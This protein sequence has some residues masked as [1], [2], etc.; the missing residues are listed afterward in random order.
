M[1]I[2]IN[3]TGIS[4]AYTL[5]NLVSA[6]EYLLLKPTLW[7]DE[8]NPCHKCMASSAKETT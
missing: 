8:A 1:A 7:K 2:K 5:A 3:P 6:T 4:I